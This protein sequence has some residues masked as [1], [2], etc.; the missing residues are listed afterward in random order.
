M[1][2]LMK[3]GFTLH[4]ICHEKRGPSNCGLPPGVIMHTSMGPKEYVSFMNEVAFLIGFG[5]PIVSP[6]PLE[7]LAHGAA[8][9]NPIRANGQNNSKAIHKALG[10]YPLHWENDSP[11]KTQ[12]RP[13]SLLGM[14][15]VYNI[16]LDNVTNVLEAANWAVQYRFSTYTPWEFRPNSMIDRVCALMEDESLCD[17]PNPIFGGFSRDL[18]GGKGSNVNCH[19]SSYIR[20]PSPN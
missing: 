7:G 12:H 4:S 20:N 13:L 1:Q 19:A 8:W 10:D 6:S 3:D 16:D 2:A 14:P 15:Y 18:S 11:I 5:D 17:C 9:L